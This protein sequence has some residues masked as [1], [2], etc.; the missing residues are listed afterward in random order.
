[1]YTNV[2]SADLKEKTNM[3]K[4]TTLLQHLF[5]LRKEVK[6]FVKNEE[7]SAGSFSYKYFNIHQM[8]EHIQPFLQRNNLILVQP[9]V[10]DKITLAII[11]TETGERMELGSMSLPAIN[12]PQNMG[13][14]ISY[15]RRYML[16][17]ALFWGAVDEDGQID[18]GAELDDLI[19]CYGVDKKVLLKF[20]EVDS[21]DKMSE[22]TMKL[23]IKKLKEKY[24]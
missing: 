13:K 10:E 18:Y 19:A 2:T 16:Q 22:D 21:I 7:A 17:S 5:N 4:E 6:G 15:Y 20:Y 14:A 3:S 1:M 9:I 24:E 23:A 12:D 8:I 11:N